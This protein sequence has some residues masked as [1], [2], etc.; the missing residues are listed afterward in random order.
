MIDQTPC[1]RCITCRHYKSVRQ[2]SYGERYDGVCTRQQLRVYN[3]AN[4]R[5]RR[6]EAKK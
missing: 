3:A 4:G 6:W 2:H 1:I 5:C